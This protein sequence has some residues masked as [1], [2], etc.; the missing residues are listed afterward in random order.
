MSEVQ[1]ALLSSGHCCSDNEDITEANHNT[2]RQKM[3]E[4]ERLTRWYNVC[5]KNG[6]LNSITNTRF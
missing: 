5:S 4:G 3:T 2:K 1:R 6:N